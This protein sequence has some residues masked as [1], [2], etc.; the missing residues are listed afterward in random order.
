MSNSS[1]TEAKEF[2]KECIVSALLELIKEKDYER[3][4]LTEIAKKAGVSRNAVYRNFETK[5][6]ILK[7]HTNDITLKFIKRLNESEIITYDNYIRMLVTHLCNHRE[8]AEILLKAGLEN[9]LLEA[10]MLMKGAYEVENS[11]IEYYENYR[12][13]GLFFIYITWLNNGCK[14]STEELIETVTKVIGAKSILPRA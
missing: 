10:F 2:T 6:L 11:I 7:K 5:N 3:I 12:I 4:T 1:N 8:T 9:I 14:E 13:G